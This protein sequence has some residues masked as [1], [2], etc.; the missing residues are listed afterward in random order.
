MYACLD[1]GG[2]FEYPK[3]YKESHGLDSPPYETW[4]GC[5]LCGGDYVKTARC[6][7]CGDWIT[8]AYAELK[9]GTIICE[10]CYVIKDIEDMG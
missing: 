9:D 3:Q 4:S 1:C 7:Q 5:P 6:D 2:I 8:G 10:E